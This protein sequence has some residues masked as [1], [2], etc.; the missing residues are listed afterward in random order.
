MNFQKIIS[1]NKEKPAV[2]PTKGTQQVFNYKDRY[3]INILLGAEL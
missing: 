1:N 2:F 3:I